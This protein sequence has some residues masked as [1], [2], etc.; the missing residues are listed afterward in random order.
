MSSILFLLVFAGEDYLNQHRFEEASRYYRLVSALEPSYDS[1]YGKALCELALDEPDRCIKVL[2]TIPD[3]KN[4]FNYYLGIAYYRLGFYDQASTYLDLFAGKKNDLWQLDYYLGLINLKRHRINEALD[5]F[6]FIPDSD[7]KILLLEYIK[8]YNRLLEARKKFALGQYLE[9]I[10]L[11]QNIEHFFGYKEVGRAIA[12]NKTGAYTQSLMLLDSVIN[13]TSDWPITTRAQIEAGIICLGLNNLEK[14]RLYIKKYS[15]LIIDDYAQFLLGQIFSRESQYD[16]AAF[17]FKD[18]PDSVDEYLFF[19]SRTDYLLGL[20]GK[21]EEQLLRHYELFPNSIYRD[22]TIFIL[23]SINFKRKEYALAINFWQELVNLYAKSIYAA[24]ASKGI[25]DAYFDLEA[26]ADALNAYRQV[27]DYEPTVEVGEETTLKI[28]ETLYHL[29]RYASLANALRRFIEQNPSSG[30][31][32]KTQLRLAR[33]LFDH[34][35]YYQS[36]AELDK[37]IE[38]FPNLTITNEAYIEKAR[39]YQII[40]NTREMKNSLQEILTN[41]NAHDYYSYAANELGIIYLKESQY[42]SALTYYRLLL[43]FEKY[44][45]QAM[46]EIA[47]IYD[48]LEQNKASETMIEKLISEYPTSI[49]LFDAYVLKSKAYK[50]R[51]D[52]EGAVDILKELMKK[53]GPKPEI[54][55]EI[56]NI[57]F[58]LEDYPNARDNYLLASEQFKQKRDEAAKALLLAGDASMAIGDKKS[59]QEYYLQANLIAKSPTLKNQASVK[60]SHSGEE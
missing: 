15:T 7:N 52:Y 35:E 20:W 24:S 16:S 13:C 53:I 6:R 40:G 25:G 46:L 55:M 42:D 23:G 45:E 10:A 29:G 9:A 2:Q 32:P 56:G 31:K 12:L 3:K 8:D 1:D 54:Y 60:I 34:H 28:Y 21:A 39:V 17:Y 26:Y 4:V 48:V 47:R 5:Y 30:L 37:I 19:K 11:Y 57:Y 33:I 18:L 59:A 27:K 51:G 38:G 43:D 58:E 50:N 36:L 41:E 49:F 22:R 44:R 14:A